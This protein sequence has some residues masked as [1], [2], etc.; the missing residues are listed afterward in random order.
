MQARAQ[1]ADE[2]ADLQGQDIPPW[3]GYGRFSTV[4]GRRS[5]AEFHEEFHARNAYVQSFNVAQYNLSKFQKCHIAHQCR[6]FARIVMYKQNRTIAAG[7]IAHSLSKNQLE[8]VNRGPT[9]E[10]PDRSN[11][12]YSTD[13][14]S[15]G[16][17]GMELILAS[18]PP[19]PPQALMPPTPDSGAGKDEFQPPDPFPSAKETSLSLPAF[20][21]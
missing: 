14:D 17:V 11:D 19:L 8:D 6:R 3:S 12:G 4:M 5:K 15:E 2:A 7:S 18:M 1:D 21:A 16:E 9:G 20:G 10:I 13:Y